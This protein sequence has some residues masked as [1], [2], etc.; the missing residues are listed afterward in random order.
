[1]FR[2]FFVSFL[3]LFILKSAHS[4]N[5]TIRGS[6]QEQESKTPVG[7]ATLTLQGTKNAG[8]F[9]TV[10]SDSSGAFRFGGLSPDSFVLKIS[11]IGFENISR[12]V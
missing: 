6:L 8:F 2:K 11:S 1:M 3:F 9:V 7:G 10:T 12:S 5:L 4:Q